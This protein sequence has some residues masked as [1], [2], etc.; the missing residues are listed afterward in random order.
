LDHA[1][2]TV[3]WLSAVAFAMIAPASALSLTPNVSSTVSGSKWSRKI[4]SAEAAA[5]RTSDKA[6][7]NL[8]PASAMPPLRLTNE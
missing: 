5:S 6:D 2:F 1:N 7:S 8:L 4:L 3:K